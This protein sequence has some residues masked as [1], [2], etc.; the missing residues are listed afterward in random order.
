MVWYGAET[1]L[2]NL[3][4]LGFS[5]EAQHSAEQRPTSEVGLVTHIRRD[6]CRKGCLSE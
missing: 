4:A 1:A 5:I 3:E 6:N 2:P